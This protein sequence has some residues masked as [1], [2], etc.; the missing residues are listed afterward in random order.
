MPYKSRTRRHY[1]VKKYEYVTSNTYIFFV[2]WCLLAQRTIVRLVEVG[3]D[4]PSTVLVAMSTLKFI[5]V[6][7][8]VGSKSLF[9]FYRFSQLK[10]Q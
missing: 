5:D 7:S 4:G 10:Q 1:D 3:N 8:T 6:N 9:V 2:G